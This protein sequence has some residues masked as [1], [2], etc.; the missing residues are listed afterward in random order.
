MKAFATVLMLII[1]TGCMSDFSSDRRELEQVQRNLAT[2][3]G[4]NYGLA[5]MEYAIGKYGNHPEHMNNAC[6]TL[7]A[8]DA[9]A[10]RSPSVF[11]VEFVN[12]MDTMPELRSYCTKENL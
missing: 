2:A 6:K 5:T 4:F 1:M 7:R 8:V 11:S 10:S 3:I 9:S 12:T